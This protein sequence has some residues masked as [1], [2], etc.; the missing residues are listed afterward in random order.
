MSD[1]GE[2]AAVDEGGNV[3]DGLYQVRI[4][5]LLQ[6][7]RHGS[8]RLEIRRGD[9]SAAPAVSHDDAAEAL[10]QVRQIPG[11]AKDGHDLRGNGDVEAGLPG[12]TVG[13]AA[14][15]ENDVPERPLVHVH[16]AAEHD[17]L[18]VQI[19]GVS[20]LQVVVQHGGQEI[21]GRAH[22]V[23]VPR[24]V[25]VDLFHGQHLGI[26]ASGGTSLDAETGTERG[27]PQTDHRLFPQF[28]QCLGEA[29]GVGGLPSPAAVGVVAVT[30]MSFPSGRS[31]RVFMN[32]RSTFAL[33]CP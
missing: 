32:R 9:G 30:R 14:E 8:R 19:E 1:V 23:N 33:S 11:K 16:H 18:G 20:L 10:L 7:G 22:G 28:H 17:P 27:L 29:D 6:E 2:G 26:A 4:Q 24:E 3:F 31:A 12:N 15:A 13:L 5:R 21:V 25:K